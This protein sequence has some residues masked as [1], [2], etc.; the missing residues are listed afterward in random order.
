VEKIGRINSL[1]GD[2]SGIEYIFELDHVK[3]WVYERS[4]FCIVVHKP[5]L[6]FGEDIVSILV[7]LG[8]IAIIVAKS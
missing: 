4:T 3:R 5:G 7:K 2:C 1:H 6:F 8:D